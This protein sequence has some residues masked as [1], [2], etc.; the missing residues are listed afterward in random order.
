MATF[1]AMLLLHSRFN[2]FLVSIF[3]LQISRLKPGT[4][5]EHVVRTKL[6]RRDYIQDVMFSV[7]EA[8]PK[9]EPLS[10]LND[11]IKHA[12]FQ[13]RSQ[14]EQ[15]CF[16]YVTNFLGLDITTPH[17]PI[18]IQ[19]PVVVLT[20]RDPEGH[21]GLLQWAGSINVTSS[22]DN[23]ICP[24]SSLLSKSCQEIKYK[25][26]ALKSKGY[27]GCQLRI[28]LYPPDLTHLNCR[29]VHLRNKNGSE[30]VLEVNPSSLLSFPQIFQATHSEFQAQTVIPSH[31]FVVGDILN[32]YDRK[33]LLVTKWMEDS[34]GI[35][36]E[37]VASFY[38]NHFLIELLS[39]SGSNSEL[40][41]YKI[42]Q[43]V[44]GHDGIEIS[45]IGSLSIKES[46][47]EF[48]TEIIFGT[49][50]TH[51]AHKGSIGKK[52]AAHFHF[53]DNILSK[54]TGNGNPLTS[55]RRKYPDSINDYLAH[56][57]QHLAVS[58]LNNVSY[59]N[60]A[61]EG[62]QEI[63]CVNGNRHP[64]DHRNFEQIY[65]HNFQ[66]TLRLS[67]SPEVSLGSVAT[68]LG[69]WI[70][71]PFNA[72]SFVSCGAESVEPMKFQELFK[73]YDGP[74]WITCMFTMQ[75]QLE[76]QPWVHSPTS[77]FLVHMD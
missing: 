23:D 24:Y 34:N 3:A 49:K 25:E 61:L 77:V 18:I 43:D 15:P 53:C 4:G 50:F 46:K 67:I 32:S 63:L 59:H 72:F 62:Y 6:E 36:G 56:V 1:I 57:A 45:K 70:E 76:L 22:F 7:W 55:L 33:R 10:L 14:T 58:V 21:N 48:S 8:A 64:V 31:V 54:L 69:L 30:V 68:K 2:F 41:I 9:L 38:V 5:L 19:K 40:I 29:V 26:F 27:W 60:S 51:S 12:S 42:R 66:S 37:K 20:Y 11:L 28:S 73:V 39:T 17:Y 16:T 47:N 52:L 65:R 71:D 75:W 35:L 44:Y 74:T 13:G